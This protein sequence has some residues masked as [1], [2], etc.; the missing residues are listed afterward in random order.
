MASI[1]SSTG[2]IINGIAQFLIAG[3]NYKTWEGLRGTTFGTAS[4]NIRIYAEQ[5]G[6]QAPLP[7]AAKYVDRS[8]LLE[9]TKEL[10]KY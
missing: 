1:S 6:A 3:K 9:A 8:Y 5:I 2:G 10:D 4:L 7:D